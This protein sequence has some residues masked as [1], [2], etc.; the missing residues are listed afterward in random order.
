MLTFCPIPSWLCINLAFAHPSEMVILVALATDDAKC[1][2]ILPSYSGWF[3]SHGPSTHSMCI[4]LD[5][6]VE[7][8]SLRSFSDAVAC[9]S[10]SLGLP[11]VCLFGFHK[12]E[13]LVQHHVTVSYS[14]AGPFESWGHSIICTLRL[15]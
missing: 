5:P 7:G 9:G 4:P 2:T 8:L 11:L 14:L 10:S 6:L 3:T 1:R 12:S 13:D 15:L